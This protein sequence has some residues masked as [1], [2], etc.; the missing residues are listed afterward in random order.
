M[1]KRKF[2][3]RTGA[4]F[5]MVELLV[6]TAITLIG[7][8]VI[9]QVFAVYEGWKRTT[10][11]VAQSQE[12]GLLGAFT[13]EQELRHAG[14]GM[15]GL[16]CSKITAY[17]ENAAPKIFSVNDNGMP[18]TITRDPATGSDK[19][20][21]LYSTSPFGSI[22]AIIQLAM[23]YSSDPL[24]V[25]NGIG[26]NAGDL[27]LIST[28]SP[29]SLPCSILQ[30][31]GQPAIEGENVTAP[32]SSWKL[33]HDASKSYP[34]NPP[35]SLDIFESFGGYTLG[36]KVLN[37]G[38]LVDRT[39]YVKNNFLWMDERNP[40]DGKLLPP[41]DLIPGVVGLRAESLPAGVDPP[42][43]I[44]FSLIIR[45]GNWEKDQVSPA[46][47][48]YWPGE[49]FDLGADDRHYRYRVFQTI[50]PLKNN[51]WNP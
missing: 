23:K 32:G 3:Q 42:A 31:T 2:A 21:V 44:R 15:I 4:G 6:A 45:S 47:I 22:P 20:N 51:I 30:V 13:I 10:T 28:P 46:F 26:F 37:L 18:I 34:W 43:A 39:F 1:D 38:Q 36:A 12:G 9:T 7:L 14:F 11:G 48:E 49:Q 27:V 40:V 25:S 41:Y 35:D 8:L 16:T 24:H 29:P 19:I 50:V 5:S 17:N 33:Q